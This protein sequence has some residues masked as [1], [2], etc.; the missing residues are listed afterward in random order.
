MN[1]QR[2]LLEQVELETVSLMEYGQRVHATLR[3]SDSE[4]QRLALPVLNIQ[5]VWHPD[6]PLEI[7]GSIP[8]DIASNAF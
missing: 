8:I 1:A 5:V 3:R 2:Q 7:H 4:E 6:K